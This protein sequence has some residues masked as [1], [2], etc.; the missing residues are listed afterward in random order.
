MASA[1]AWAAAERE[2]W[3]E[4]EEGISMSWEVKEGNDEEAEEGEDVELDGRR[5]EGRRRGEKVDRDGREK[6]VD[7]LEESVI[8]PTICCLL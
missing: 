5:I 6:G 1:T 3:G 2:C 4:G 8:T 7:T